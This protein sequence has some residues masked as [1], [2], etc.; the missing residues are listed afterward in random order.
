M[1]TSTTC[2]HTLV[3]CN[4]FTVPSAEALLSAPFLGEGQTGSAICNVTTTASRGTLACRSWV[5][6]DPT[7]KQTGGLVGANALQAS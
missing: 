1:L 4:V 5:A 2:P 3:S 7:G 6:L